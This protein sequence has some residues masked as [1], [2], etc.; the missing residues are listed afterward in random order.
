LLS[1]RVVTNQVPGKLNEIL[2]RSKRFN[3]VLALDGEAASAA[4]ARIK[5]V[6]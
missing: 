3:G 6:A 1:G 5:Q 4:S 2:L